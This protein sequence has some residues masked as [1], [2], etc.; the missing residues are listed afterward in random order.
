MVSKKVKI[1]I[2]QDNDIPAFAAFVATTANSG[3]AWFKLNINATLWACVE[4]EELEF[5]DILSENTVH[6]M[7][8]AFQE[9]YK[10]VFDEEEIENAILQARENYNAEEEAI[11][12]RVANGT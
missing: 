4:N 9:L 8:H 6:E 1:K 7:M 11:R 10:R 3:E 12:G 5:F 2:T